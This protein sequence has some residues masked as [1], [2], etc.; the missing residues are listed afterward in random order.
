MEDYF[1]PC[2]RGQVKVVRTHHFYLMLW[3]LDCAIRG[4]KPPKEIQIGK[5]EAG[6]SFLTADVIL[7]QVRWDLE[8]LIQTG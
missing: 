5:K 4:G 2:H 6:L 1:P 3:V 7:W 8:E